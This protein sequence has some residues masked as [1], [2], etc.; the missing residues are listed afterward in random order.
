MTELFESEV[1][2]LEQE[3]KRLKQQPEVKPTI[4]SYFDGTLSFAKR[5]VSPLP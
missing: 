2:K 5:S 4:D 1:K 3:N